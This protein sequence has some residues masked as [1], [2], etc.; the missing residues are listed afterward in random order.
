MNALGGVHFAVRPE[1][2]IFGEAGPEAAIFIPEFMRKPGLQGNER[3]V[4]SAL[5][6]AILS[7]R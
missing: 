2:A 4:R 5:M 7:L 6:R 3:Q 1:R